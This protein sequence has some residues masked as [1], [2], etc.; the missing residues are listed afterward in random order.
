M[1]LA[2]S[3]DLHIHRTAN[4]MKLWQSPVPVKICNYTFASIEFQLCCSNFE[5]I[6]FTFEHFLGDTQPLCSDL[7]P[8]VLDMITRLT[9]LERR[10][11]T[12]A[13]AHK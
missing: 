13:H 2:T 8:L 12:N 10:I 4:G 3:K 9:I 7:L 11:H 5:Q 1:I 6:K